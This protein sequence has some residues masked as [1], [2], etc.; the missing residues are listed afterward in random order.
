MTRAKF[1]ERIMK[2]FIKLNGAS[3]RWIRFASRQTIRVFIAHCLI[4]VLCVGPALSV[5]LPV[6]ETAKNKPP[7]S[8][9][10]RG[11]VV[12][13][14]PKP[15]FAAQ[16]QVASVLAGQSV[17]QLPDG[18]WLLIGGEVDHRA[19]D[20]VS[21]SDGMTGAPVPIKSKLHQARA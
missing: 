3:V 18:R 6:K 17:T 4:L 2:Q 21:L 19:V 9:G 7:E 15:I 20:T 11:T 8:P 14:K 13:R 10:K 16:L 5:D 12:S 1:G